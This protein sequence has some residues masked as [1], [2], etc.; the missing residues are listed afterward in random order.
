MYYKKIILE[1]NYV[2]CEKMPLRY[3]SES[4]FFNNNFIINITLII[5]TYI[6]ININNCAQ[7]ILSL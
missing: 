3:T 7:Q 2:E 6:N 4:K 5:I 1:T